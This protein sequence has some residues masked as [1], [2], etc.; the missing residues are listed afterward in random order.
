MFFREKKA[1]A[2]AATPRKGLG[3]PETDKSLPL[4]AANL[5][6]LPLFAAICGYCRY[7]AAKLP[8]YCR[9]IAAIRG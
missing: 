2:A 7:I 8:L 1:P 9:Y 4:F 3:D 6:L 5:P